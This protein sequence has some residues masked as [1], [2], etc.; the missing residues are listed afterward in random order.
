MINSLDLAICFVVAFFTGSICGYFASKRCTKD[1]KKD[2]K[3]IKKITD[4][5]VVVETVKG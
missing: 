5:F 3:T 1:V 4:T 2:I